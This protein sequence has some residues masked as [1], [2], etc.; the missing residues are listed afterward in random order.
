MILHYLVLICDFIRVLA[1]F[2]HLDQLITEDLLVKSCI[3]KRDSLYNEGVNAHSHKRAS[4]HASRWWIWFGPI[5]GYRR[6]SLGSW[7]SWLL[8]FCCCFDHVSG[9]SCYWRLFGRKLHQQ[10]GLCPWQ[11][12]QWSYAR[13]HF[14]AYIPM[15]VIWFGT[16]NG[17]RGSR[18]MVVYCLLNVALFTSDWLK[19]LGIAFT[20]RGPSKSGAKMLKHR[21]SAWRVVILIPCT[22]SLS[23]LRIK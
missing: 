16:I 1:T 3:D 12:G 11:R 17:Y 23:S 19:S 18:A 13:K 21:C 2:W 20:L 8:V 10:K 5:N 6:A 7:R 4:W 9:S 15:V 14:L 22:L